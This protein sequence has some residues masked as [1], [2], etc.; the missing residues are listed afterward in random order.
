MAMK[1]VEYD[2]EWITSDLFCFQD[3]PSIA[4]TILKYLEN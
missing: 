3:V 4:T 1:E 2:F